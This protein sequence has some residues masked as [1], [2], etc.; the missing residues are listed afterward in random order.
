M[1]NGQAEQM[2]DLNS[3]KSYKDAAR[4]IEI[5][6]IN[7]QQFIEHTKFTMESSC[8]FCEEVEPLIVS[9]VT[10]NN[11]FPTLLILSAQR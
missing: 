10:S 2:V 8:L 1:A 7:L 6:N 5:V 9:R 4:I 11:V 3:R